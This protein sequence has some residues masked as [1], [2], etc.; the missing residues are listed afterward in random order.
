MDHIVRYG[1]KIEIF[2]SE[3]STKVM[4]FP[5]GEIDSQ[6]FKNI[7]TLLA[8]QGEVFTQRAFPKIRK[9]EPSQP[10]IN[11]KGFPPRNYQN[12]TLDRFFKGMR[13]T[14]LLKA[15][16]GAGKGSIIAYMIGKLNLSTLVIVPTA[17]LVYQT[18]ERIRSILDIDYSLVGEMGE[19]KR[20]LE[21]P[22]IVS[23]WQ[24]LATPETLH[25][26]KHFGFG[27]LVCDEVHKASAPV[28]NNIISSLAIPYKYGMSATPYRTK[29][30]QMDK[31]HE[32][33]GETVYEIEIEFLYEQKFLLRPSIEFI[34]TNIP[35]SI[36]SG[37]RYFF[38]EKIE[39]NE[40]MRY[41]FASKLFRDKQY[42]V[43]AP[44]DRLI[45]D[46]VKNP[47]PGEW[48]LLAD[49]A[50]K[51]YL[52]KLKEESEDE[53]EE[54]K[55]KLGLSKSGIELYPKRMSLLVKRCAKEYSKDDEKA[56]ILFHTKKA[57][58]LFAEEMRKLGFYNVMVLNG[59][60]PT[61]REDISNIAKGIIK[62]YIAA[63]TVSLLSEGNDFPELRNIGL[64]APAYSPFTDIGRLIQIVGR[65]VRP[66][67]KDEH[68]K[69]KI[70]IFDDIGEGWVADKKR[71]AYENLI[72]E[73][74]PKIIGESP[75]SINIFST[76]D[77]QYTEIQAVPPTGVKI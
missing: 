46:V 15:P 11:V 73:F 13:K 10:T 21:A 77:E 55:K 52:K 7:K 50:K 45:E 62:N 30:E 57:G 65:A 43:L 29:Q 12:E 69:P 24:S 70:L 31:V 5:Y 20:F 28:L 25:K 39:N 17:D 51:E 40:K 14:G 72:A 49:I 4:S 68:K 63:S 48:N 41:V 22:I 64:G 32:V 8:R 67:P 66:D 56:I 54:F 36:E 59:D 18:A 37:V 53:D 76:I 58:V 34:K 44:N 42:N 38:Y 9:I 75:V 6:K 60:S 26:M 1:N 16:T 35:I 33:L 2:Q 19:K 27:M 23:T 61:K 71:I 3:T 74:H 47:L